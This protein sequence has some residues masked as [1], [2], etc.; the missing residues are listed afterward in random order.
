MTDFMLLRSKGQ[1]GKDEK[2][3]P[4]GRTKQEKQ[5]GEGWHGTHQKAL[6]EEN[7]PTQTP[8]KFHGNV[9]RVFECLTK[10]VSCW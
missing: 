7:A 4:P 9:L 1:E 10:L 8:V 2:I 5:K 3:K 6:V